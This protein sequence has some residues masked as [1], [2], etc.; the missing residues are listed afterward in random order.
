MYLFQPAGGWQPGV[1]VGEAVGSI[2]VPVAAGVVAVASGVLSEETSV[3]VGASV[4]TAVDM[5]LG[6]QVA[7]KVEVD[8]AALPGGGVCVW[9]AATCRVEADVWGVPAGLAPSCMDRMPLPK[10]LQSSTAM[11]PNQIVILRSV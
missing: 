7:T 1:G 5:G 4:D 9:T 10:M 6:V 2:A 11:T 8:L 3:A